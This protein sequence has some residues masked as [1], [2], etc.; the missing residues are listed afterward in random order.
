MWSVNYVRV[1]FYDG[2]TIL[3]SFSVQQGSTV[4]SSNFPDTSEFAHGRVFDKWVIDSPDSY[5][6]FA[7]ITKVKEDLNVYA[8]WKVNT[9]QIYTIT[10]IANGGYW[11]VD[12]DVHAISNTYRNTNSS[13]ICTSVPDDPTRES[14]D[15]VGWQFDDGAIIDFS[16]YTFTSDMT[17]YASWKKYSVTFDAN[18]KE[19]QI[20]PEDRVREINSSYHVSPVSFADIIYTRNGGEAFAGW[21]LVKDGTM[22]IDFTTQ[23]FYVS[24]TVYAIWAPYTYSVIDGK[25]VLKEYIGT[26]SLVV[27]PETVDGYE[28]S[29]FGTIFRS[30]SN[31]HDVIIRAKVKSISNVA[32][33]NC[34][35]LTSIVIPKTVTNIYGHAFGNCNDLETVYYDSESSWSI[36]ITQGQLGNADFMQAD[37]YYYS[38]TYQN[39]CWHWVNGIPTL[40]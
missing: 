6:P 27:V 9:S 30:N 35:N 19:W 25:A 32:F 21:S 13:G 15:F 1:T 31:I 37:K 16:T 12:G 14:F 24:T 20:L 22:P 23:Q 3:N 40:W 7:L 39:G 38:E 28:V 29:D 4:S 5:Y 8:K 33:S 34:R 2:N 18:G 36:S 26:S 17:V 10:F 11:H